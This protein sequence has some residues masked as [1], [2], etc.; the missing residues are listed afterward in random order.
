MNNIVIYVPEEDLRESPDRSPKSCFRRQLG[1][2]GLQTKARK[3]PENEFES[4]QDRDFNTQAMLNRVM[5]S[6]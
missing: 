3:E 1:K 4:Q 5:V 2:L 6:Y